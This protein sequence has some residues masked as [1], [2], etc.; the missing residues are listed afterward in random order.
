[1]GIIDYIPNGSFL[2]RM[3]PRV[4]I[5]VLLFYS[6]IVFMMDNLIIVFAMFAL[7]VCVWNSAKLPWSDMKKFFKVVAAMMG[8]IIV[9]QVLF[10]QTENPIEFFGMKFTKDDYI[11]GLGFPG[12]P[13]DVIDGPM[14]AKY[15]IFAGF[16]ARW[17]GLIFSLLLTVRLLA[18]L[19]LMPMVI[20]STRLDLF[21]LGLV[22]I[23]LPYRIAY[24]ATTAINMV[25][26]F[27]DEI[28]VIMDAQKMRGMTVFEE[29]KTWD[30]MKAWT[31]LV[32]PLVIGAMRRAQQ[33]GVAMDTRAFG[34]SKKRT[35]ISSLQMKKSDWVFGIGAFLVG[36]L[37]LVGNYALAFARIYV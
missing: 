4:K 6:I 10:F 27:S 23:G 34:A 11:F 37:L 13:P 32:V 25:P 36:V 31:T 26:T 12:D 29:G 17:Q 30:K 28:G 15:G 9:L 33:M 21:S 22:K 2:D 35:F 19:I 18:L 8:F 1:M 24:M 3:D 5:L 16:G 20:K 7:G 14:K